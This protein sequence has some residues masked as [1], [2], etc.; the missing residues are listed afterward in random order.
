MKELENRSK[1][2]MEISVQKKQQKEKELIGKL[3]PHPGHRVWEINIDTLEVEE[4]KY[5]QKHTFIFG[6]N[7]NREIIVRK[8]FAYI[9]ALNKKSALK[10]Y[11]KGENGSKTV[12][13]KVALSHY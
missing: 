8:G 4:A 3:I 11:V 2:K 5:E 13:A 12:A 7:N 1:D 9:A 10:K 6:Q